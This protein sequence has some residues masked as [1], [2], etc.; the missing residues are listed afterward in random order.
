FIDRDSNG[1]YTNGK[2][3]ENRLPEDVY[4]YPKK[5]NLKKNWDVSQDWNLYETPVELQKPIDIKKNKPKVKKTDRNGR[6]NGTDGD[7]EYDD[8]QYY[9]EFGNPA[10]DPN[11]PFGKKKNSRYNTLNGRDRNYGTQGAGYR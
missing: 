5:L 10:V 6:G 3:Q 2:L 1:V 4:Y 7:D 9:D 11:D 8:D